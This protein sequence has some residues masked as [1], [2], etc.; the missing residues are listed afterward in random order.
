MSHSDLARRRDSKA[1]PI[2]Q[3]FVLG[4]C[5][6]CEPIAFMSIFPYIYYM[7][8]SFHITHNHDRVALYAGLVTSVFAAAECLGAGFWGG[9]SDRIGRKP[10]LL[11]G[12]AGTGVSMLMFG[13]APNLP[14]A[15]L[16]R[17][18]GGAL[19]GNI[20]VLQTTVN[21]VVKVEAHQAR[22][23]AIMPTVWCMGAFIGSALG[24]ALADPVRTYPAIFH[25]GTIFD[26]FP[27][28]FT[29]LVCTA[30]V[31]F[32]MIVGVLF[33][34]ETHEDM[35]HKPD[36]G[37]RIGNWILARF[38]PKPTSWI[39]SRKRELTDETLTLIDDM[40]PDYR[41]TAS[42]PALTP[43]HL[44]SLPPPAY[45]S[46][47]ASPR[48]S[49]TE[50]ERAD[51]AR[52]V[53]EAL[54]RSGEQ[55]KAK[56]ALANAFTK[57]V[58]LNITG[59]GILAYHTISAEQ[60]LPVLLSMPKADQPPHLPFK[61]TGGFEMSTKRIGGILSIQGVIQMI[62]TILVFPIVNRKLGSLWT[63]RMVVLSY[64]MLYFLVPYITLVPDAVKLP[65]IYLAIF[66][67]V[68][69]QAFA[70]PSSSI[71]LANTAPSS[72]VLGKLN[73]AAASAASA[74]RAFGPTVSGVMQ[75]AGLSIGTLG[76][77]WWVNVLIAGIG[78]VIGMFM[79]EEK[80]RSFDDEKVV[81]EP[82]PTASDV[83]GAAEYGSGMAVAE[84]A[85]CDNLLTAPNSP[86]ITRF[87]LDIRRN[88]TRRDSKT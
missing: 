5:R 54:N 38:S 51:F 4:L 88:H 33:L 26:K 87:S 78:A 37:L 57:Q 71:M 10:I 43:S 3:L 22:A 21:E 67:K 86:L 47:D 50:H 70:F 18:V 34:E 80:R 81:P 13:F 60:L 69:A 15:L 36:M 20:G 62:A 59:Y 74:C 9:L 11:T 76:L 39:S 85:N 65:C 28:L 6:I 84:D 7:I 35:K 75:S 2:R 41:S 58:M 14:V 42:S 8:E 49:L 63:Y 1:F 66:W 25:E 44:S 46:I 55:S 29:N 79:A 30:V 83:A 73:G 77:P 72:K 27:Y 12:L 16:A 31:V 68:T 17:A 61:F 53:E 23:Y 24:G 64:P 48:N 19:N 45:R 52:D 32:S 56:S 40:P 82:P